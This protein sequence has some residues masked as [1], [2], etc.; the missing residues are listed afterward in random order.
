[1]GKESRTRNALRNSSVALVCQMIYI[2]VSFVCRTVFTK[3]LG[4]EYLGINGLFSNIITMLSFAEL[5]IG[6]A[7]VYRMYEPIA[8]HDQEKLMMWLELYKKAYRYIILVIMAIGLAITPFITFFV[9]APAVNENIHLL[10]LLY[11]LDTVVS[12][13]YVYKK[14][15]LIADQKDYI[16]T[17]FAQIFNIIMNILQICYLLLRKDFIGY[18]LIRSGCTLLNNIACSR[19]VNHHYHLYQSEHHLSK[20]DIKTLKQDVSGLVLRN[21]ANVSFCGTDNIILS[22]FVGISAVGIISNYMLLVSTFNGIMNKIFQSITAT[23]GNLLCEE[24]NKYAEDTL[25]KMFFFNT[26]MYGYVCIGM[27]LLIQEFI[28]NIWFDSVYFLPNNIIF[29]MMLELFLRGIHYPIFILRT[30]SGHFKELK[31][32][33]LISAILNIVLDIIFVKK[34]GISGV[35]LA[36]II[37]YMIQRLADV[38]VVYNISLKK[39]MKHYY[40]FFFPYIG[41]IGVILFALKYICGFIHLEGVIGFIIKVITITVVYTISIYMIFKDSKEYKYYKKIISSKIKR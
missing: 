39:S 29:V 8:Q 5:G 32:I 35:Y 1:M 19:Y 12:Y 2:V 18:C 11:L 38:Y 7:L 14:S 13:F 3:L 20:E 40:R 9:K 28:T 34:I 23:L 27:I 30:A 41:V 37:G 16:V 25:K 26:I 24:D 17:V 36:T 22:K 6:S 31:N 4:S 33:N 21:I 15:L 10:Y